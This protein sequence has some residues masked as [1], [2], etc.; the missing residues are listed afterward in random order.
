[1]CWIIS[2]VT[3]KDVIDEINANATSNY[4]LGDVNN[5]NNIDSFDV[6][7]LR[8]AVVNSDSSLK[9]ENA[10]VNG[11]NIIDSR[12][13]RELEQ[14][15]L[16]E[17]DNFSS[18]TIKDIVN[19]DTTIVTL[20]EPI[21]TSLTAE[22]AEK[23]DE[24]GNIQSVYN[25][26]YNNMRSEFYYGSRKGAI[27]AFEQGGG[28]D[29]DLSSLLIAMLRYLGYDAN[30]VTS[31][32]GF[33]EEQLLKLTNTDSIDTAK[34]IMSNCRKCI[35]KNI[36]NET[37]YLYN[38]KYV[39]V[40]NSGNN[41][42]LDVYFKEYVN[43]PTIYDDID[44]TYT[45][46]KSNA[47]SIINNFDLTLLNSEI[48]KCSGSIDKLVNNKYALHSDKIVSKN[49]TKLPA[50]LPYYS[51][52][53]VVSESLTDNESDII[54]IGFNTND[55]KILRV[56]D[57]YNKNI[58][59]NYE[60]YNPSDYEGFL[61]TSSIFVLPSKFLGSSVKVVP[62]IKIDGKEYF[63]GSPLNIGS[64]QTLYVSIKST[65]GEKV[66]YT[67]TLSAGEMCSIVFDTGQI[68]ANEL[69]SA[70]T[71]AL[72]NTQTINQKNNYTYDIELNESLN[73]KLNENNVYSTDYLG[74]L[75]RLAGVMYFSQ[76][77]VSSHALAERN[78][79]HSENY[80]RFGVFGFK[81]SV[82]TGNISAN[83][84]DGIQ[85]EGYF[86][87]D[88]LC[89][90]ARSISKN[91]DDIQLQA[92]NFNR[93]FISSELE[94]AVL[95]EIFNVES[96]STTT[97]FRHA[98]ENNIPIVTI[99]PTSETKISDLKISSDDKKNIQA[100]L[101]AGQ[102]VITTQ[103]SVK[104][105]S[106]SGVGYIT[107]SPDGSQEY[108]ISGTYKGGLAFDLTGLLYAFNVT[109]D[110]AFLS[111]GITLLTQAL[112]AMS[113]LS[114]GTV[115]PVLLA[116]T[117]IEFL[118][119]DILSQSLSYYEYE[120]KNDAEAGIRIWASSASNVITLATIG[121]GKGISVSIKQAKLSAKFGK[122]VIDNIK[123]VG[124]FSVTEIN[125]KIKQLNKLGMTQPT[126][127]T[128]IKNPKFMF[129][130]DDVLQF[131]SKQGGNQRLL[132]ELVVN[133]GDD[134]SK[135]LLKTKVLDD[136]CD[137]AW[138]YGNNISKILPCGDEVVKTV[139]NMDEL[140]FS[141]YL[142][143][144]KNIELHR[145]NAPLNELYTL[146]SAASKTRCRI[147]QDVGNNSD[148]MIRQN[149]QNFRLNLGKR[150][151]KS[152]NVG[153]AQISIDNV[154]DELYA[155]AFFDNLEEAKKY[156]AEIDT[157]KYPMAW[158]PENN[159]FKA[160]E[161][162]NEGQS[163][164]YLRVVCTEYKILSEIDKQISSNVLVKGNIVLFTE[165]EC[166]ESCSDVIAQFIAKHPNVE[167]EIIHNNGQLLIER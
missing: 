158:L 86:F 77:D 19:I 89:N 167:I 3:V 62:I 17:R 135:A 72:E 82:Y 111:E 144:L 68:S 56:T 69:A 15:V 84:K 110:L 76:L 154:S 102:T 12:D 146:Y 39:Q 129:L 87:V 166:C 98:Q 141:N 96:L 115:L 73:S 5:D 113:V 143:T 57:L 80:I 50:E 92:F 106:W 159:S 150:V 46:T 152:S 165:K 6:A 151:K 127:D 161:V 49:I 26:L 118:I 130:G 1:M 14:F 44:S 13:L 29:T 43:Q 11:D 25:Y 75:L 31:E 16:G 126:I 139:C 67:E 160:F 123:N 85:K 121:V 74:S 30:Y 2:S 163:A 78:N 36:N 41:Y 148:D 114:V 59:V 47:D 95:E 40:I 137:L 8:K 4:I 35:I 100:E 32:V 9:M 155:V 83:G 109:F 52:N 133:N 66:D 97:I 132:A 21:E 61:D 108:M 101:D 138:K 28:N 88:I 93:G 53:I 18:T 131:L 117:S 142:Q 164:K 90:E 107:I 134:F 65:G 112:T 64:T 10:D 136:F 153:Y 24:L 23:A 147:L 27:G 58:T 63:E 128:L 54:Y 7:I 125:S 99:Y 120:L 157:T 104:L 48:E 37:Y 45:L 145:P 119:F 22:M 140:S 55:Q 34:Y 79:I 122:N 103:S 149:V 105:G 38:Y 91:N 20:D 51:T 116:V 94:S 33:T 71:D 81:P 42:Y 124:G 60:I 162:A 156:G 70:Y